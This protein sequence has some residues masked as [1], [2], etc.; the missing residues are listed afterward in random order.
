MEVL[1]SL[2]Y[3]QGP[4]P[5]DGNTLLL[6]LTFTSIVKQKLSCCLEP[7][8]LLVFMVLGGILLATRGEMYTV[9]ATNP[10]ICNAELPARYTGVVV[11]RSLWE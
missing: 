3:C 9:A 11:A 1:N 5:M 7:P 4:S 8:L 2:G 10:S 6:K